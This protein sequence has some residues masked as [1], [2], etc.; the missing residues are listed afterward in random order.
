MV[1]YGRTCPVAQQ[2][3]SPLFTRPPPWR[4][5][6]SHVLLVLCLV[7]GT[8]A[9]SSIFFGIF[10]HSPSSVIVTPPVALIPLHSLRSS[11]PRLHPL[12]LPPLFV[13][14][15]PP[16]LLSNRPVWYRG[17]IGISPPLSP[18]PSRYLRALGIGYPRI[19]RVNR[20]AL[21]SAIVSWRIAHARL[22]DRVIVNFPPSFTQLPPPPALSTRVCPAYVVLGVSDYIYPC[23]NP[24]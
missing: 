17:L 4:C 5:S 20:E 19:A 6:A 14:R 2:P 11:L 10:F 13:S 24:G 9:H 12:N 15:S 3:L 16:L 1:W 21:V 7:F 23:Q 22:S 8:T 18:H